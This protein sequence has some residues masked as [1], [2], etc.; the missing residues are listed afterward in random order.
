[1]S[2]DESELDS[3]GSLF[4]GLMIWAVAAILLGF[5]AFSGPNWGLWAFSGWI[6]LLMLDIVQSQ[7]SNRQMYVRYLSELLYLPF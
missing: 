2:K 1:M 7:I 4:G 6:A 3:T 5:F